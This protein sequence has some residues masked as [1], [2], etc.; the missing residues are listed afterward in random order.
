MHMNGIMDM[1]L[2]ALMLE[3]YKRLYIM[4]EREVD[5]EEEFIQHVVKT[6]IDPA[7]S[8]AERCAEVHAEVAR[9]FED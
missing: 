5:T 2:L 7:I 8:W 4:H 6:D 1:E 9:Q 3:N